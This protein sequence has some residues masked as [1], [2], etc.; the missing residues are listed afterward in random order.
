MSLKALIPSMARS[1]G[2]RSS[3]RRPSSSRD[4]SV[5]WKWIGQPRHQ[6]MGVEDVEWERWGDIR[7]SGSSGGSYVSFSSRRYGWAWSSA[8]HYIHRR[9][10][11]G[12]RS[13][14]GVGGRTDSHRHHLSLQL[15][16]RKISPAVR[17]SPSPVP[18]DS[19]SGPVLEPARG[20][21]NFRPASKLWASGFGGG[22]RQVGFDD[23]DEGLGMSAEVE[24]VKFVLFWRRLT[25]NEK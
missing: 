23:D 1:R 13:L 10:S 8:R 16:V 2:I 6:C 25:S 12:Q 17:L 15:S 19:A 11:Y 18:L 22:A 14:V 4:S 7:E 3:A 24:G 21:L 20:F 9:L 5:R